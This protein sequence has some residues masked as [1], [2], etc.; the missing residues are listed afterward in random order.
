MGPY[1]RLI[2]QLLWACRDEGRDGGQ[3]TILPFSVEPRAMTKV[4]GLQTPF[5]ISLLVASPPFWRCSKVITGVAATTARPA[6]R[7]AAGFM[8]INK[9]GVD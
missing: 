8:L 2:G 5:L 7:M 3:L 6:R 9:L 1:V 4:M